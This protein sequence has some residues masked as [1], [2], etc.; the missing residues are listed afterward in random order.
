[1]S[2]SNFCKLA[3]RSVFAATIFY[4]G[5]TATFAQCNGPNLLQNGSFELPAVANGGGVNNI[6][7]SM[8]NWTNQSTFPGTINV[9]KPTGSTAVGPGAAHEGEQYIDLQ[10]NAGIMDQ[11]F[12]L[13]EPAMLS[14][15]GSFANRGASLPDYVPGQIAIQIIDLGQT[16]QYAAATGTLT[17]AQGETNWQTLSGL[18]SVLP[19][20]RYIF[21]FFALTDYAHFDDM[22]V[23]KATNAAT[24]CV[25]RVV[26]KPQPSW[27]A[28]A[29]SSFGDMT[30]DKTIDGSTLDMPVPS[31]V[32]ATATTNAV[33]EYI[34][35]D[36]GTPLNLVGF[37]Y[38]PRTYY[39][40]DITGYTVQSS[41]DG[42]TFTDI[43]TGS[44]TQQVTF[45]SAPGA[46]SATTQVGNP[47]EVNFV[48]AVT[49]R[50][51]RVV[52]KETPTATYASI[53]E[54]LPIVCNPQVT[55]PDLSCSNANLLNTGTNANGSGLAQTD[56]FDA[57]WE[58]AFSPDPNA[59]NTDALPALSAMSNATYFPAVVTGNKI[60]QAWANSPFGNAEWISYTQTSM[61]ANNTGY[62]DGTSANTYF[63][64]YRFNLTDAYLLSAFKLKLNFLTDN[65]T[66]NI[67]VNGI[68]QAPQFGLPGGGF[69]LASQTETSLKNG[70][71]LGEN[72]LIVQVFSQP[73]HAGFLGQNIT[74]CPGLD[75]GDAPASYNTSRSTFAA[76]HIL[77]VN[78]TNEVMLQLGTLIDAE[79]DGTAS[80]GTSDNT[81][82]TNDEDGIAS[83]PPLYG[84]ISPANRGDYTVTVTTK[85]ITGVTANLC[86]WIDWNRNGTFD[87]G[88]SACSTVANGTTSATLTWTNPVYS[89]AV[90]SVTYARFRITTDNLTEPNGAAS[91]G[92]VEDYAITAVVAPPLTTSDATSTPFN[93]PVN[94]TILNNDTP[95]SS[96]I[97]PTSVL[98]IDPADNQKK[99]SVTI[100]GEGTYTVNPITG[101]VTF[102]PETGFSGMTTVQYT[103]QDINNLESNISTITV[104]TSTLPVTLIYFNADKEQKTA[105]LRWAT[106]TETNSEHFEIQ[107]STNGK[108]WVKIGRVESARESSAI[109]SYSFSHENPTAGENLYRLKMVDQDQTFAFSRISAVSFD[110]MEES[111]VYPNPASERLLIQNHSTLKQV[112]IRDASGTKILEFGKIT[113]NGIDIRNLNPGLYSVTT[114]STNGTVYTHKF[115]VGR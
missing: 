65:I 31:S 97:D 60:P 32:W 77:E 75:F 87:S 86:G 46:T 69:N 42:V 29:T 12:T 112:I 43:Q 40:Q 111:S 44:M 7:T 85:N 95:G 49:A 80:A 41:Q 58:V 104:T 113:A 68:G 72:E 3:K 45:P 101:V 84:G 71:K 91:N 92:E 105:L 102:T 25:N 16:K 108:T 88:E 93:T 36:Y 23:C 17:Q 9:V 64:R 48:T 37:V 73:S 78:G 33:G 56:R 63:F 54:L 19:A 26:L 18:T 11:E 13:D 15:S 53:A 109:H 28:T 38:Y 22:K 74:T 30:P 47:I 89:G 27:S 8:P 51:M 4:L 21:R 34:T 66:K 39:P 62:L 57:N 114:V 82:E 81:M 10:G 2:T 20:G 76:G 83:F 115:L 52:I 110:P 98:F 99:T 24:N 59:T 67:Y 100:P 5:L 103:I 94:L 1:M 50:Y 14:F 107:H 90:G 55:H 79:N 35:Y 6:V 61:D 70:W 96:T 106:A